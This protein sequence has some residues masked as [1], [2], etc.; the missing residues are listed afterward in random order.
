MANFQPGSYH[1]FGRSSTFR[2]QKVIIAN[3][4]NYSLIS[5]GGTLTIGPTN[6]YRLDLISLDAYGQT[7]LG[8]YIMGFN[9]LT[10]IDELII[11]TVLS[12]PKISQILR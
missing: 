11:G 1:K 10:S 4:P 5:T 3:F 9:Q 8:W 2:G 7:N 12:I 6:E